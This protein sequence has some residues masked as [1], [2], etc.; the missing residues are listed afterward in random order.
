VARKSITRLLA[1]KG[2]TSSDLFCTVHAATAPR[3]AVLYSSHPDPE[4]PGD[5]QTYGRGAVGRAAQTSAPYL[6]RDSRVDPG[7][8][9]VYPEVMSELAIPVV[10]SSGTVSGVI[11]FE[12][13][14][15]D[16]FW[17]REGSFTDTAA[18]VARYFELDSAFDTTQSLIVPESSIVTIRSPE[19]L[20]VEVATVSDALL[21]SL[22]S[23][24]SLLHKLEPR[25]F[26]FVVARLL[27]D[28][29]YSVTITRLS[30]DG[31]VD[32]LAELRLAAG[33]VLTLV[34]CKRYSPERPVTIAVVRSL[35]GVLGSTAGATNAMVA[36]TSRFTRSGRRFED[37]NKYR[38]KLSDY[39]DLATWL[40]R[41]APAQASGTP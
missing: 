32:L 38:L 9:A 39:S 15:P 28:L 17:G 13:T 14:H 29:G 25:T 30:R 33:N 35:Y 20:R 6:V 21:R 11:N 7:Y 3:I 37:A 4:E 8:L 23:D 18:E 16:Y 19:R 24:P 27:Q 5:W 2:L 34:E 12:S 36:T 22:A 26:E 41:Y 31:G 40:Q 10:T 1:G